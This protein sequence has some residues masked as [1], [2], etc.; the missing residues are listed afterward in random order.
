MA[1]SSIRAAFGPL[2]VVGLAAALWLIS[3]RLLYVGPLDRA[4]FGWLVVIPMWA[5]APAATGL[6]GTHLADIPR[7]PAAFF[8]GLVVGA[9]VGVLLWWSAVTMACPPTQTPME[10]ALRSIVLG[11]MTGG[12]F[13]FA[14]HIA[15]GHAAAGHPWRAVAFGAIPQL[16]IL[17]IV[18]TVS[19]F[20][21]Y[22]L[23]QRPS[24]A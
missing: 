24:V 7:T 17:A 11:V 3:D 6:A 16:F 8:D 23:C 5:A 10:L 19:F 20:T 21:F 13:A 22:G 12:A 2:L 15:G 14:C 4:T 9:I 1:I 18:P